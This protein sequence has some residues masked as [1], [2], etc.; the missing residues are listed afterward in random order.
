VGIPNKCEWFGDE[1]SKKEF[2]C[3]VADIQAMGAT[4]KLIDYTP[5]LKIANL[6]YGSALIAERLEVLAEFIKTNPVAIN[7][8]VYR[9][10]TQGEKYT[11]VDVYRAITELKILGQQSNLMWQD[12][13]V[14]MVPTAPTHYT[15]EAMLDD[16]IELNRRLGHYTNFVNLLDYAAISVPSSIR[17]DGLPFGIT[18]IAPAG[19]DWSLIDLGHRYHQQTM[20]QLGAT[21]QTLNPTQTLSPIVDTRPCVQVAVV[22]AHLSGMPLNWQLQDCGARLISGTKTSNSYRLYSLSNSLPAK[23]GLLRVETGKG[24]SIDI[25]IWQMPIE[26]YGGFVASI[27]SPLGIGQIEIIDGTMVQGFVCEPEGLKDA[28]DITSFKGWKKYLASM[29]A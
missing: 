7:E 9:I 16:P 19:S 3:A 14:L 20:L 10:I 24:E 28:T 15:I 25:E 12:I 27:P 5:L 18:L 8:A 29:H 6:L 4:V 2:Q 23:P 11:A 21:E 1:L 13:H 26:A 22:G 17:Q